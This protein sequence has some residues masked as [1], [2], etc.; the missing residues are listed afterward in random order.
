MRILDELEYFYKVY[1]LGTIN[2]LLVK[3]FGSKYPWVK[4]PVDSRDYILTL[5]TVALPSTV[6]LRNKMP[7]VYDQ[8][9]L[10]SCTANAIGAAFEYLEAVK[11]MPSRLFIYY[12]ER[13]L[14]GT[15]STDAGAIIRDGIKVVVKNGVCPE[16]LWPYNVAQFAVKPPQKCYDQAIKH[17]VVKYYSVQQNLTALKT[18]LASNLPIVFGVS[19]YESFEQVTDGNIPM[20]KPS[21]KCLGGHAILICGYCD[22][23]QRFIFRNSWGTSWGQ[24]GYGTLPYAY[25]TNP[26]LASDFWVIQSET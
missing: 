20:P 15:V 17:V 8:G 4:Q 3:N 13:S 24:A 19:V 16:S 6:D 22:K 23:T 7:S 12:N 11:T 10:G 14:E 2:K 18:A 9:D 1:I 21:E 5:P 26:N 25:V